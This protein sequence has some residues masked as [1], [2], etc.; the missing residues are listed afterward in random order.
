MSDFRG[1]AEEFARSLAA[2]S[3]ALHAKAESPGDSG[4]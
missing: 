4:K 3:P 2:I 1:V